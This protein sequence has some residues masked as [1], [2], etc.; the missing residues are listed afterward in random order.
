MQLLQSQ[1][2]QI[3]PHQIQPHQIQ[4]IQSIQ[5][6]QI[7]NLDKTNKSLG[8]YQ[9]FGEINPYIQKQIQPIK[10]PTIH[11][12]KSINTSN[13]NNYESNWKVI[14]LVYISAFLLLSC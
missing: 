14:L 9:Q 8:H 11:L 2:E 6:H 1:K 4:Q 12:N 5:P 3:Q 10:Q 7:S 13:Q